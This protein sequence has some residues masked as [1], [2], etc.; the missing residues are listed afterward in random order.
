MPEARTRMRACPGSGWGMSR[1][2]IRIFFGARAGLQLSCCSGLSVLLDAGEQGEF[3]VW[4]EEAG[5]GGV[6]G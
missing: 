4:G 6:G 2:S 5:F 3:F 1:S